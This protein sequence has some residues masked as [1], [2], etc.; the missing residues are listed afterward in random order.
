M[1]SD[2]DIAH[3]LTSCVGEYISVEGYQVNSNELLVASFLV[4]GQ[5]YFSSDVEIYSDTA[6]KD[7]E[8]KIAKYGSVGY[9]D[10]PA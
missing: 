6:Y 3:Q 8:G 4:E 9:V 2:L 5:N 1:T 7:L 10:L